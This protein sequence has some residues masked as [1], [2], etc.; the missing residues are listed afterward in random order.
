[1]PRECKAGFINTYITYTKPQESPTLFHSWTAIS[2]IASA[3]RRRIWIDRGY[4]TLYPNL[5]TILVSDSGVGRKSTAIKIGTESLLRKAIPDI[6]IMRGKLTMGYLVDWMVQAQTKQPDKLA[7]VTVHCSEFKVFAKGAY[8]DSGL[9][10]DLTDLY[11]CGRFEY[12]TK[13]QGVYIIEKPCINIIAASTP[14][15]LT[16]GSAA[17]FIGGGF[18]SRIV[19]VALTKDERSNAWPTKTQIEK[20]LED[21]LI[22]DLATISKL[23]GCFL[24]TQDGK[25]Y[26]ENWYTNRVKYQNPDQRMRGYFSK[27][28]DLVLKVAMILSVSINDDLVITED[29]VES[30]LQLLGKLEITIPFAFQGVAWGEQAKFQDKVMMKIQSCKVIAHSDLL[31]HFHYCMTGQDLKH[32]IQTLLDEDRIEFERKATGGKTKI[33]YTWKEVTP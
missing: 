22:I 3:L 9:I 2:T 21:A 26:F 15:W 28:H 24:I 18:S 14:E 29:H 32:I 1:M 25:A 16:T 33:I 13:N 20:D 30:A 11:D 19:P 31:Q 17:D 5:Y 27:K 12:R 6:T 23:T 7:E 10:E 4:Y 8:S